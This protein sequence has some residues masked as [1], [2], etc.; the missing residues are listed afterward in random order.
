MALTKRNTAILFM[1]LSSKGEVGKPF[2]IQMSRSSCSSF[3]LTPD[4][5]LIKPYSFHQGVATRNPL[6]EGK[7]VSKG[8]QGVNR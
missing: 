6:M 3:G 1:A 4:G 7:K 5:C 2:R 8:G